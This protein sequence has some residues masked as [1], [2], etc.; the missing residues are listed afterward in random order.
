[1]TDVGPSLVMRAPER[2]S[3]EPVGESLEH[4][5][6]DAL[7]RPTSDGGLTTLVMP[8]PRRFDPLAPLGAL[9]GVD[10]WY[11]RN[12]QLEIL[13]LGSARHA[14]P[15]GSDRFAE[16]RVLVAQWA[17]ET[18]TTRHPLA[19]DARAIEL[20]GAVPRAFVGFA[21]AAGATTDAVW[22]PFG[23]AAVVLPR[24][25]LTQPSHGG[26]GIL[27]LT[28]ER[29]AQ[30]RQ[31][32]AIVAELAELLGAQR[33][34]STEPGPMRVEHEPAERHRD[35]VAGALDAIERGHLGKVV[36][37]RRTQIHAERDL[38]AVHTLERFL[39]RRSEGAV[40]F[41]RRAGSVLVGVTPERLLSV[42]E[43][44]LETE[45]LAGTA[46]L[47]EA[48][49]LRKSLKDREEHRFVVASIEEALAPLASRLD[50]AS[51]AE[52][53]TAGTVVHLKT[54]IDATLREG[55]HALEVAAA[56]HPTPAVGGTPKRAASAWIAAHEP[57]RGWY[58]GPLGW[59][60]ARG[61][62][63]LVVALRGGVIRGACAWA[64]AGGG[65]VRGSVPE[66]ELEEAGLKV[67]G[68][69]RALGAP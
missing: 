3:G 33:A 29:H 54:K 28:V 67:G 9:R 6:R 25:T 19:S 2:R 47:G 15:T 43:R 57:D 34:P 10:A 7:S 38:D 27:E 58:G 52:I 66:R 1:M 32:E 56:L 14:E 16:A 8:L 50:V 40:Y 59:V 31:L 51:A 53:A 60:D 30:A 68:F 46:A 5:V 55:T 23:D 49:A 26:P 61:N 63:E 62:G 69:L 39:D 18:A 11:L 64:F 21:F 13:G 17:A 41:V 65:I 35:R 44:A 22:R 12:A 24:W 42:H 4:F 45:A 20:R 37:S 36:V 48:E